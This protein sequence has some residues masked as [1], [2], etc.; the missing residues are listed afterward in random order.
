VEAVRRFVYEDWEI[1]PTVGELLSRS[2]ASDVVSD[3]GGSFKI[4]A[5][6]GAEYISGI[7][8]TEGAL[9]GLAFAQTVFIEDIDFFGL[10]SLNVHFRERYLTAL[11]GL[12]ELVR[13]KSSA[14][15]NFTSAPFNL[16]SN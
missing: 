2:E 16:A 14:V 4:W 5:I 9:T 6:V 10:S 7:L 11:V 13:P 3:C 12:T 1:M 15:A 8:G